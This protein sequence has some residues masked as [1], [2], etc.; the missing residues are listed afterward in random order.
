MFSLVY[1][2]FM[3]AASRFSPFSSIT[4][5]T[6]PHTYSTPCITRL[7]DISSISNWL[8]LFKIMLEYS[9]LGFPHSLHAIVIPTC[10]AVCTVTVNDMLW[11][12]FQH[13][14]TSRVNDLHS[15]HV[16]LRNVHC[17]HFHRYEEGLI[18]EN[19]PE[20]YPV[21]A[22]DKRTHYHYI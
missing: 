10:I 19:A 16:L 8:L 11:L 17:R 6:V 1:T 14:S 3:I 9:D 13:F 20:Y 7:K 21:M 22:R 18:A 15:N 4:F 2:D 5:M 12:C